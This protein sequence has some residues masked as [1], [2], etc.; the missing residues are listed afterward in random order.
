MNH[1]SRPSIFEDVDTYI[2][3][4]FIPDD[5]ALKT[6]LARAEEAGLPDMQVSPGQGKFLYLL[7][8]LVGAR[9]ILEI[10]TLGGYS[11]LWLARAMGPGGKLTSLEIDPVHADV[12][13]QSIEAAGFAGVCDVRTGAALTIL[14]DL[15]PPF[16]L[17]FLDANKESYPAYLTHAV[18]LTRPGGL[19]LADNVV[20]RGEILSRSMDSSVIGAAAFNQ[21][22]ASHP[23]LEA[24]VLQQV[25]LKGHDGM[26]LARVKDA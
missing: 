7:A 8:K 21:A 15:E 26:A 4:L 19:I 16:D 24:I 6:A 13:R 17:V 10:G 3:T 2:D 22:L 1:A 14:P 9:R 25:G 20:R 12:A 11:T 23:Q 18:R 5:P